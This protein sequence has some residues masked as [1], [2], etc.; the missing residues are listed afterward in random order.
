MLVSGAVYGSWRG[1]SIDRRGEEVETGPNLPGPRAPRNTKNEQRDTESD[2]K[3]NAS[4]VASGSDRRRNPAAAN[5]DEES[6]LN[7]GDENETIASME[8][9]DWQNVH[10]PEEKLTSMPFMFYPNSPDQLRQVVDGEPSSLSRGSTWRKAPFAERSELSSETLKKLPNTQRESCCIAV[11][12]PGGFSSSAYIGHSYYQFLSISNLYSLPQEDYQFLELKGCF[13]LPIHSILDEFLRHYFLHLH[14]MLPILDE[15]V[16]WDC[17]SQDASTGPDKAKIS[18]LLFQAILFNCCSFVPQSILT[19]LGLSSKLQA[20]ATFHE[21]AKLLFDFETE[22]SMISRSQ[23]A[24]LMA[25]WSY[26][27]YEVPRKPSPPWLSIAIQCAREADAHNY[28]AFEP[29]TE[30]YATRKR[31]WWGCIIR[32]HIFS[33]GMRRSIQITA[34]NFDFSYSSP[35]G[36]QDLAGELGKS[37][38]HDARTKAR[39]AE[40]LELLVELCIILTDVL[41]VAFPIEDR[42]KRRPLDS[43]TASR[44]HKSQI[45]LHAWKRKTIT[46]LPN[47]GSDP[48]EDKQHDSVI[49]FANLV[50]MYYYSTKVT[51]AHY[52]IMQILGLATASTASSSHMASLTQSQSDLQE[53]ALGTTKCL[54]ELVRLRLIGWLPV[55]AASCTALPLLLHVLEAEASSARPTKDPTRSDMTAH[56]LRVLRGAME[57]Y[58]IQYEGINWISH[59]IN[60]VVQ[61]ARTRHK[62]NAAMADSGQPQSPGSEMDGWMG[63]MTYR[64]GWYIQL[65]FAIDVAFSKGS[66]PEAKGFLRNVQDFA[67]TDAGTCAESRT[68]PMAAL[69]K[70]T[71]NQVERNM[72]S[73]TMAECGAPDVGD[74]LEVPSAN[75]PGTDELFGQDEH[76]DLDH[77]AVDV[78]GNGTTAQSPTGRRTTI[79]LDGDTVSEDT[80]MVVGDSYGND[81]MDLVALFSCEGPSYADLDV[82]LGQLLQ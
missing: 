26:S 40:I 21:R 62:P 19:R 70:L 53:A 14:P 56:R 60:R 15:G 10:Q 4:T 12:R 36:Y 8:R 79:S 28:E 64:P 73:S 58:R 22:S 29:H 46:R 1:K 11:P 78:G 7:Q 41:D 48:Y 63:M 66:L 65:A 25:S 81:D 35:L 80:G 32:D 3:R 77:F 5:E 54:E 31:L 57:T 39:L 6:I 69:K 75:L 16:F 71:R 74:L 18:L 72:P 30:P 42:I 47:F 52:V 23:A 59:V 44:I 13:S 61:L 24:L 2:K 68:P 34:A 55:T 33:L 51:A 9:N 37:K 43:A 76:V 49:L 38:V 50:H 67:A 45:A 17:Y 27:S 82:D 20:R